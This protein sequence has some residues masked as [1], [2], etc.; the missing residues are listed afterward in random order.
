MN[1]QILK[2]P[3]I[4]EKSTKQTKKGFYT[5]SVSLRSGKEEIK[6]AV[7]DQFNVDVVSIRTVKMHGKEKRVG[8][9]GRQI[10]AKPWKKAIVKLKKDQKITLFEVSS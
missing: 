7:K 9:L 1:S 3:V 2:K 5:F 4:T 6:K 8:R 10:S